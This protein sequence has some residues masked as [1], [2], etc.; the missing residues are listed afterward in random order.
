VKYGL[1]AGSVI[2][3]VHDRVVVGAG[4]DDLALLPSSIGDFRIAFVVEGG[5]VTIKTVMP[6]RGSGL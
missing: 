4:R 1:T 3:A 6:P 5:R 2:Q